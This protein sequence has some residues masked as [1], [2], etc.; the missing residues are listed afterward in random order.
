M[1]IFTPAD[2]L[3][4][5]H[6]ISGDL[7]AGAEAQAFTLLQQL[8]KFLTLQVIVLNPG[9][10]ASRLIE[11]GI[12]TLIMDE[13]IESSVSIFYRIR[14]QIRT[15][16]P[17]VVHTHRTKE[18]ILG[19]IANATTIRTV[20]VRTAHGAAEFKG[21]FKTKVL[22]TLDEFTAT[23]LQ[24]KVI[25]VS[26]DLAEQLKARLKPSKIQTIYN[27]VNIETLSAAGAEILELDADKTHIGIIGRLTPV[28]RVD[29]F[30]EMAA[31][32]VKTKDRQYQFHIIGNGPLLPD[33]KSFVESNAL[34]KHVFFHG[35]CENPAK[36]IKNLD[37]VVMCSDHEGT[38]MVALETLALG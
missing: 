36:Y 23:Y 3:R 1:A 8:N 6:I 34:E 16:R 24:D 37:L 10:L 5:L 12:D 2:Q 21:S 38:P 33:L 19:A 13:S 32:L 35:H 28:K 17:H 11:E 29:I 31:Q 15:F 22:R 30:L 27:G 7:W 14:R 9:Q 20:C 18:N 26:N 25:A 4:N